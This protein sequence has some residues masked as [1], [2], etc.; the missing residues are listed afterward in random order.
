MFYDAH[1]HLHDARLRAH[2]ETVLR[3][4][5]QIGLRAA[6]VNGTEEADWPL[7]TD[8]A[9]AHRWVVPSYGLHPW[10]VAQRSPDWL[11]NLTAYLDAA[12]ACGQRVAVG[13]IG[14]DR[15]KIPYDSADQEAVF[16]DQLALASER[17]LPVTIH[18]LEAWGTLDALLH[19]HPV[20]ARGFLL[21]AY[22][23]PAEMIDRFAH[24]GAYF[25]FNGYFLETRREARRN[26]FRHVPPDRLLVETDAPA[27]PPPPAVTRFSLARTQDGTRLNH[28]ASLA[29]TYPAL[30]AL[31]GENLASLAPA[32]EANFHRFFGSG[33]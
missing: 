16:L 30:A 7:V 23:G 5:Q 29:D 14:L 9:G 28:P 12:A 31:R 19:H 8:L 6:V 24:R 17:N 25:S 15:W 13:E 2:R 11:K 1:N 4:L 27:M 26:A 22:G 33:A 3:D 32:I 20:P 10:F 21:H 18:C